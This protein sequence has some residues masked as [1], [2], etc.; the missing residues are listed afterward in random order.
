MEMMDIPRV[1][2]CAL[3][4]ET[5]YSYRYGTLASLTVQRTPGY[6]TFKVSTGYRTN[7]AGRPNIAAQNPMNH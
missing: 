2:S 3:S 7:R 5:R 1:A 6:S 4:T